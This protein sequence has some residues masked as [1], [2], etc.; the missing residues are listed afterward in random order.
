SPAFSECARKTAVVAGILP[1]YIILG[2]LITFFFSLIFIK[3]KPWI[4]QQRSVH[5]H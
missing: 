1:F 4:E 3:L 5:I 2:F